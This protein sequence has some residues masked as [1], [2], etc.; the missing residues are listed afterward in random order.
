MKTLSVCYL[1]AR[2][3]V[4][5]GIVGIWAGILLCGCSTTHTWS[6]DPGAG[7]GELV[8]ITG[9]CEKNYEVYAI[10]IDGKAMRCDPIFGTPKIF[11]T[12]F[13]KPGLHTF[14]LG[15]EYHTANTHIFAADVDYD[16]VT[17]AF[18]TVRFNAEAGKAYAVHR[19]VDGYQVVLS[20]ED[21]TTGTIVVK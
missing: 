19:T 20:V 7:E 5:P 8:K 9:D 21:T 11:Q 18:R 16:V 6:E 4:V 3:T 12:I 15:C 1:A 2:K 14:F 17:H 13:V 10:K